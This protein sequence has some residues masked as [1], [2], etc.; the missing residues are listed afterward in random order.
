MRTF[1]LKV[2]RQIYRSLFHPEFPR[3]GWC[4]NEE[5]VIT[6]ELITQLLT[7]DQP[8]F[9]GRIGTVEGAVVLNYNQIKSNRNYFLKLYDYITDET[10]LPFWDLGRPI[11]ELKSNAGFFPINNIRLIEDFAELY[12]NNIPKIDLCGRFEYYEKF[13]PFSNKC[14]MVQ[15]ETLYPFFVKNPWSKCLE[16]KKVLVIH[17]FKE[18]IEKQYLKRKDLF[19][20]PN[21]LPDF[22]LKVLKAVQTLAGEKSEYSSWFEALEYMKTEINNIDFDIA[23]IGCGAYGLPL[24]S[25]VKDIGKKA[26]HLGGGT[27]LLFGIK[28]KRWE[29]D[30]TD[31]CYRNLFNENW[32]YPNNNERPKDMK[33]VEGGCYW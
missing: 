25:H 21:I 2:I 9:I 28:G 19:D 11:K 30:Y 4:T 23:I 8:C 33:I 18:S 13:L 29:K 3:W 24:A 6:N 7:S 5:R 27:Q 12:L 32:V 17:P 26:I 22:N 14:H 1:I 15:L 16:N 31:P 10:R 20:N